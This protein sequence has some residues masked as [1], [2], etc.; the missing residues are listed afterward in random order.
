MRVIKRNGRFEEVR[1]DKITERINL[2]SKDLTIDPINIARMVCSQIVD[3]IKTSELDIL[4][5]NVCASL[6]VQEPEYE[7]LGTRLLMTNHEKETS[8]NFVEVVRQ[9]QENKDI[10]GE[11]SP[12]LDETFVEFI[13]KNA[14]KVSQ[15]F[16][17]CVNETPLYQMSMFGFK[18][19]CRSYLM[20]SNRKIVERPEHLFYRVAL[21]LHYPNLEKTQESYR[22]L[23]QGN[24]IHATPTL[25]HAGTT[26]AQ[27]SSCFLI[28]T[29]DNVE[30]IYKTVTDVAK[31]SKWAGGIGVHISNIRAKN[32]YIRGT[33]GQSNGIMPM[34]RVYNETSRYIDQCVSGDTK[35]YTKNGVKPIYL[36]EPGKDEILQ[37]NGLFEVLEKQLEHVYKG[38]ILYISFENGSRIQ[39]TPEH[40]ILGVDECWT[41]AID[42]RIG[43]DILFPVPKYTKDVCEYN[44][45]LLTCW[46]LFMGFGK[47]SLD[48]SFVTV[49]FPLQIDKKC[50]ELFQ[51]ML[52]THMINYQDYLFNDGYQIRFDR[53]HLSPLRYS[54]LYNSNGEKHIHSSILHLPLIKLHKFIIG[55][56]ISMASSDEQYYYIPLQESMMDDII[57]IFARFGI[58][59]KLDK[60][61]IKI[62]KSLI[63]E[64]KY[65]IP[66]T[67]LKNTITDVT[68]D[69]YNGVLYDLEFQKEHSYVITSSILHNGGGKRKGSF[70]MYIEPW[71]GDI[72]DFVMARRNVGNED[73]R[74]RDLFYGLWIP[75]LFM[76]RVEEDGIWSLMCPDRC[77][78]LNDT[79][80][81][82]FETLYTSYETQHKYIRQ[83]KARDLWKEILNSQIETGL[84]YMLYKD[85]CNTK[86]NQKNLGVIKSSNLCVS[87]DTMIYSKNGYFPIRELENTHTQVWNG[88]EFSDVIVLKTGENQK[89]INVEFN[90]GTTIKCTPYHKFYIETGSR[91]SN[92]SK[93]Q[94]I[95]AKDLQQNMKIIRYNIPTIQSSKLTINSPYTQGIFAA[96]GTYTIQHS[97]KSHQCNYTKWNNTEFCK[98]HQHFKCVYNNDMCSAESYEIKPKL[99]LYGEKKKLLP[100]I[101]Y[102]FVS[103]CKNRI[104]LEL[105]HNIHSKFFVPINYSLDTRLRWLEGLVDGDGC[106]I[107]LNDLKNIQIASIEKEF[108]VNVYYMLQTLGVNSVISMS[109]QNRTKNMPDGKGGQKEYVCKD[110]YR[111]NID[112]TGLLHL[113]DLG[114]S[115]KRLDISNCRTPHHKTN[116]FISVKNVIDKDEYEDTF[117]FNEPKKHMGIFNGIL[118]GQCT[119]IIQ[120]S[121][122]E[123]YSVCNLASINLS[124]CIKEKPNILEKI[125]IYTKKSCVYCSLI[126]KRLERKGATLTIIDIEENPTM[127]EN[128]LK[129]FSSQ[130]KTVPKI[131]IESNDEPLGFWDFWNKYMKPDFDFEELQKRV[132]VLVVNMNNVIDKNYYPTEETKR[133]N[134]RNRPIGLGVQGLADLFCRLYINFDSEEARYLNRKIFET[135]Y[136]TALKTSNKYCIENNLCYESFQ[137]S[138]LSKG[139]FHFELCP[140]F[141][142]SILTSSPTYDWD[143]LRKNIIGNGIS[144]SLFIA[145]MPTASTSQILNQNECIEPYTSNLYIRRTLAGEFTI[146]NKYLTQDLRDVGLW[147]K[148]MID[149]LIVSKGSIQRYIKLPKT[150]RDVF[151]TAWEIPQKSLID[152]AAERQWFIDQSQSFNLFVAEPSLDKLTKMH[153][154][155]WKKGLKTGSYYI[156]TKPQH[157]SQNF[158]VDPSAEKEEEECLV[159]SA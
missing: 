152:M 6:S 33:N 84:P 110:L 134:V 35:V 108:L 71:H 150:I 38:E 131:C 125:T 61:V 130:E 77:K 93:I 140:N 62:T 59:T 98:R 95:E 49:H 16:S 102:E 129:S 53:N 22:H 89:L 94:I 58:S 31:I 103:E 48:E 19:L 88:S 12:I 40:P 90:N 118:T 156:R 82:E 17:Q 72:F 79:Y 18:T 139:I 21:F 57:Y 97:E 126:K 80:G 41:D 30:G 132:E 119:E 136:Y 67:F 104:S 4:S 23:A 32:S 55:F 114:F 46:G 100:Y 144:N 73:E 8:S 106:V 117:C 86:S 85:S 116:R 138:P 11:P 153:F 111:I 3:N 92:K 9:L 7:I 29:E 107:K 121:D 65:D 63:H 51:Y 47:M 127:F 26:R 91:P 60:H 75:D 25:F 45:T 36:L 39:I 109:L 50:R 44:E 157:F 64:D 133:S 99:F 76:K 10:L 43:D 24:F 34:L 122:S 113:I 1:F 124:N 147:N 105:N 15:H 128:L 56:L 13:E 14:E 27:C 112:A 87:G 20:K 159:C 155:G 28:G 115:P 137:G 145:P 148:N 66:S 120:Y 146:T 70:A 78:G 154:Y 68:K 142:K 101:E 5:A 52:S 2:L 96:E 37:K 158:T 143:S 135:M 42:L 149:H 54:L 83:I 81:K 141:D 151:R 69:V 74:A 123:N